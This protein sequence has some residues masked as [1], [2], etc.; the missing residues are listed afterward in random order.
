[1]KKV[2]YI[3]GPKDLSA[4]LRGLYER[5]ASQVGVD[6]L[7][8]KQV[9]LGESESSLVE[10]GLTAELTRIVQQE[11]QTPSIH[12]VQ[13]YSE[14]QVLLK[15]LARFVAAA[16]KRGDPAIVIATIAHQDALLLRLRLAGLDMNAANHEG[17]YVTVDAG[18][19]LSIFM[20]NGMPEPARFFRVASGLIEEA[21]KTANTQQPRVAAFGEWVSV[22][23]KRGQADAA[24]RLEQ[25]WNELAAKYNLDLLC[26]YEM[27]SMNRV[28]HRDEFRRICAEHTRICIQRKS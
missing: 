28:E 10:A 12:E 21:L 13:F 5:V 6:A 2:I 14:D 19:T 3:R 4:Q 8:V 27:G 24:V 11:H 20:V 26:G 15:R 9:A 17:R 22:L 18:G 16:L 25:L 1:M 7:Y 23:C